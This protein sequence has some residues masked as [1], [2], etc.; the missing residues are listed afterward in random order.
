M[1]P[2]LLLLALLAPASGLA[3]TKVATIRI[4]VL[5]AHG[6]RPVKRAD[7]STIV[8]PLSPYTTPIERTAD[9]KGDLSLIVPT[10]GQ[11]TLTVARHAGCRRVS[12]ADRAKGPE[13][14][15]LA[16]IL[17]SGV[18][19]TNGCGTHKAAITPGELIVYVR[20]K[21][22]WERLRD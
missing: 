21:H 19:E 13:R 8:F 12:K 18:I 4:R 5:N 1:K 10:E 3:Q 2:L 20:P 7:T 16:E 6:G 11:L 17:A 9:R 22:W 14:L 15:S